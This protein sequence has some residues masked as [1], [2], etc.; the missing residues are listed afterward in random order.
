MFV[1]LIFII[2][3]SRLSFPLL[4]LS[5]LCSFSSIDSGKPIHV[6]RVQNHGSIMF[7][8][9]ER[10][11]EVSPQ[12]FFLLFIKPLVCCCALMY[13]GNNYGGIWAN[14]IELLI[15][16]DDQCRVIVMAIYRVQHNTIQSFQVT[17]MSLQREVYEE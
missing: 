3:P 13:T 6:P 15:V 10:A 2:S 16:S 12:S 8:N 4:H 7:W 5:S 14:T 9:P 11:D 17:C 1:F